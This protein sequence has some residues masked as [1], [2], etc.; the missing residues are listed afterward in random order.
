MFENISEEE[1]ELAKKAMSATERPNENTMDIDVAK[2]MYVQSLLLFPIVSEQPFV[3]GSF[4]PHWCT[5]DRMRANEKASGESVRWT[6]HSRLCHHPMSLYVFSP[7]INMT[8]SGTILLHRSL[9][10]F[11]QK[12]PV[13]RRNC[14][15]QNQNRL[16]RKN[17]LCLL[18]LQRSETAPLCA[19]ARFPPSSSHGSKSTFLRAR[20]ALR[21]LPPTHDSRYFPPRKPMVEAV[22]VSH[23]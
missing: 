11:L 17:H 8:S 9:G 15:N 19:T 23:P 5:N 13:Q 21:Y 1:L 3:L 14:K 6:S 22:L 7:I 4:S 2:L 12:E 16:K 20:L 18:D 10:Q